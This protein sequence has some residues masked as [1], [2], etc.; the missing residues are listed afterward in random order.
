MAP[1]KNPTTQRERN[2]NNQ[3]AHFRVWVECFF[4]RI[5][6]KFSFIRNV[7]HWSHSH[8]DMDF[9]IAYCLMNESIA[10]SQLDV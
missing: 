4:S 1:I 7:Y 3:V 9:S 6:M 10:L 8:F 2:F 5:M